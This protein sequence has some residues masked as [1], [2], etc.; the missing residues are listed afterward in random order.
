MT[1]YHDLDISSDEAE[2]IELYTFTYQNE[3][4]HYCNQT[5]D[6]VEGGI[7]YVPETLTREGM[8]IT[9]D[10]NRLP[11]KITTHKNFEPASLFIRGIVNFPM[12]ISIFRTYSG[13]TAGIP[14]FLIFKGRVSYAE[15]DN[16]EVKLT[17]EPVMTE[18][19]TPGIRRVYEPSCT[20]SLYSPSGCQV[21]KNLHKINS[22]VVSDVNGKVITLSTTHADGFLTG[23]YVDIAGTLYMIASNTGNT[24]SLSRFAPITGTPT[25]TLYPG[26]NKT[27]ADCHNKFSNISRYGGFS[28]MPI[29]NP[30]TG[31][32]VNYG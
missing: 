7:T 4:R 15:F 23:G 19:K 24:I 13:I 5:H 22:S 26:C 6:F 18:L 2:P 20:H 25:V 31:D 29:K 28:W 3:V 17:C 30:F 16:L 12:H 9:N 14:T 10:M 27:R 11:L 1:T 21:D 8:E 32:G